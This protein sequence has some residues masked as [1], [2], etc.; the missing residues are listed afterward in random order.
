MEKY[1]VFFPVFCYF[2]TWLDS[3]IFTNQLQISLKLCPRAKIAKKLIFLKRN[4]SI[5]I[6]RPLSYFFTTKWKKYVELWL[7]IDVFMVQKNK[8]PA[9]S[10]IIWFS[11]FFFWFSSKKILSSFLQNYNIFFVNFSLSCFFSSFWRTRQFVSP[12]RRVL[13]QNNER[14]DLV[15]LT[16]R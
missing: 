13:L 2:C 15:A 14:I 6:F 5:A 10:I 3:I 1:F 9:V 16:K 4:W 12:S 11:L 7:L 8:G